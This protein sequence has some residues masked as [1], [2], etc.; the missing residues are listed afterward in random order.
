MLADRSCRVSERL[1]PLVIVTAGVLL[2]EEHQAALSG[3]T[4]LSIGGCDQRLR[5]P[6]VG[7]AWKRRDRGT[8]CRYKEGGER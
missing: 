4:V 2:G 8:A 6:G 1:S 3:W 5:L 7:A